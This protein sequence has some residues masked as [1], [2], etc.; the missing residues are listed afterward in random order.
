MGKLL[1][2]RVAVITGGANGLGKATAFLFSE[3]GAKVV[4]VDVNKE[5]GDKV[6]SEIL[7]ND[8]IASFIKT[9]ISK[10]TEVNK[11]IENVA[12]KFGGIDILI[13][14][15]GILADARLVKMTEE[16][17]DRVISI[18]LKGIF[19]CGQAAAKIM[20]EKDN[21]GVIL[22]TSS[23]VGIYGNF[24]QSNYVASK[25]GVIGM[26]KTWARELG[27]YN[28]RVNAVAPGFMKTEIIKDMPEKIINYMKEKVYL[29][30]MG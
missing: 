12:A 20:I 7:K 8:G 9:D 21:G 15:A 4:V 29:K 13:N 22:N 26:T 5:A 27:K 14:N 24:G 30:R 18:N 3:H 10:S 16:E 28:I 23:V 1:K 19:L 25:A 17:W 2:D 11:M 6:V